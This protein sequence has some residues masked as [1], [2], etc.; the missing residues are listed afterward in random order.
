MYFSVVVFLWPTPPLFYYQNEFSCLFFLCHRII[1]KLTNLL[2]M[3]YCALKRQNAV[4]EEETLTRWSDDLRAECIHVSS[5]EV[6]RCCWQGSMYILL[7]I[8]VTRYQMFHRH[9][10][11]QNPPLLLTHCSK[12]HQR[13]LLIWPFLLMKLGLSR[14]CLSAE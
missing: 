12:Y 9:L 10:L 8:N 1:C 3:R 2:G 13:A 11:R 4:F 5:L 7:P 14:I 6:W